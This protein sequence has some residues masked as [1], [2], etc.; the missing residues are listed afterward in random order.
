MGNAAQSGLSE[1]PGHNTEGG[2]CWCEPTRED[3]GCKPQIDLACS[4]CHKTIRPHMRRYVERVTKPDGTKRS[5]LVCQMC[6]HR[7]PQ[8]REIR[9]GA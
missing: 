6:S 5:R 8:A 2:K 7:H 3:Y 1:V 4:Y 9:S